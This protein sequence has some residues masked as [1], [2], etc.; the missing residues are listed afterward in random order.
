MSKKIVRENLKGEI[1]VTNTQ[2]GALFTI[3][4]EDLD[5]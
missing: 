4:L 3:V 1:S 5:E 2:D